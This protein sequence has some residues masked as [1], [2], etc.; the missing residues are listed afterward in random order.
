MRTVC[1]GRFCETSMKFNPIASYVG[2][3]RDL[4]WYLEV[5]SLN[6]C[7]ACLFWS[8]ASLVIGWYVFRAKSKNVSEEL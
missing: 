1:F 4:V 7:L 5:P 2:A 3:A 8:V 6:R